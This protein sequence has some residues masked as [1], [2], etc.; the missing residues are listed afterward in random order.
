MSI[1][2]DLTGQVFGELKVIDRAFNDKHNKA[3]WHCVCSC[4]TKTIVCGSD[5]IKSNTKSCG[6]RL[7]NKEASCRRK[8]K[9]HIYTA[10]EIYRRYSDGDLT[11]EDFLILSQQKCYY[12]NCKPSSNYNAFSKRK[13]ALKFSIE[14]GN[15]QYNGLDRLDSSLLHNKNNMVPCCKICNFMKGILTPTEFKIYIENI[16][17]HHLYGLSPYQLREAVIQYKLNNPINEIEYMI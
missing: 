5:L 2:K 13:N 8:L 3:R 11:F 16:A 14:N 7:N 10:K 6:C 9:P 15:F 12:C 4:G 17:S 1:V